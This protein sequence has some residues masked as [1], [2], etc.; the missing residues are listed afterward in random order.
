MCCDEASLLQIVQRYAPWW[1]AYTQEVLA[2]QGVEAA[3]NAIP[4]M[5]EE[6]LVRQVQRTISSG[7][8]AQVEAYILLGCHGPALREVLLQLSAG[9][10]LPPIIILESQ[11][12]RA[13]AFLDEIPTLPPQVHLV[14][15]T[16]P[17]ALYML[18]RGL[19]LE[20]RQCALFFCEPPKARCPILEKWRKLFLGTQVEAY[21]LQENTQPKLSVGAILHPDESHLEDFFAHIPAWVHEVVV[22][23]DS[24][25][26]RQLPYECAAP[27]RQ[28]SRPLAGDFSAQRNALLRHCEGHWFLYLDADE[29]FSN[30]TWEALPALMQEQHGGGVL[31]PRVT[32][33][34]DEAHARMAYGLW[35][36]VQLRLFPLGSDVHFV[37]SVHEKVQGLSTTMAPVLAPALPLLHYSHVHKNA[38]QLRQRLAVFS[39]A[40][41][42]EHTL[43]AAYPRLPLA[44]FHQW[45]CQRHGLLLRLPV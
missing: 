33:E 4:P 45:Q 28:F 10:E 41:T 24:A 37:G 9:G 31:F 39:K 8:R 2:W 40:G 16:S 25:E 15:D 13:R 11:P 20:P 19:G 7:A 21:A 12:A 26:D 44:F 17:W 32:F 38:A 22:L 43:S 18:T 1:R 34:G 6:V 42:V 36:D 14:A 35:P 27:L 30:K 5:A 3:S 29:R 23:W